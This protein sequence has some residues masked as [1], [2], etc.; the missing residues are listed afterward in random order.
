MATDAVFAYGTLMTGESRHR[1]LLAATV[2]SVRR[3]SV[4]GILLDFGDY[5]GLILSEDA[6]S[7]VYGELIELEALH[8]VIDAIDEEEG[9]N[10]RR[11]L[12]KATLDGDRTQ[13]A[14][15]WVLAGEGFEAPLLRSGD[16]RKRNAG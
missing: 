13:L 3:A 12:V 9:H 1:L 8:G 10:F 14:W 16:W 6:E 11:E 15:A 7:R 4:G 2:R 5:P